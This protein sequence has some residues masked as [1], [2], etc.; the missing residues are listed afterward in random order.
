MRAERFLSGVVFLN[1]L[2][3]LSTGLALT[4]NPAWFYIH[5]APFP[6]FNRHFASD[7]GIFSASLGAVLLLVY[8]RPSQYKPVV[9]VAGLASVWHSAN[10]L[11]DHLRGAGWA[12]LFHNSHF[13]RD[14]PLLLLGLLTLLTLP[15][16]R[17]RKP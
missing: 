2:V 9:L 8:R 16:L 7:A 4:L 17:F 1:G 13:W 6:P 14:F 11:Y 12:H 3:M 5:L 15:V 10:H